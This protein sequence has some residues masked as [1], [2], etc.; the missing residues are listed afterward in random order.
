MLKQ[1]QHDTV[2]QEITR[3]ARNDG[4]NKANFGSARNDNRE[5]M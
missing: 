3:Q 4:S 2:I 5:I 1:I